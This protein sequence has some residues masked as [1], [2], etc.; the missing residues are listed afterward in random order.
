MKGTHGELSGIIKEAM[1]PLS[2]ILESNCNFDMLEKLMEKKK[3]LP[4]FRHLALETQFAEH[5]EVCRVTHVAGHLPD[6]QGA[7]EACRTVQHQA[8]ARAA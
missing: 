1:L 4:Q 5:L 7:R 3:N 2:K 8:N 6:P